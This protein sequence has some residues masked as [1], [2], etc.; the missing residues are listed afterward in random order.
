MLVAT[1]SNSIYLGEFKTRLERLSDSKAA[2]NT[3]NTIKELKANVM[4]R[5]T[6]GQLLT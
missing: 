3:Y 6:G 5:D 1:P 2:C 4:V